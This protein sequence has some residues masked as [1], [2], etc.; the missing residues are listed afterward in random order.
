LVLAAIPEGMMK[1]IR[2]RFL[3]L[4]G[5]AAALPALSRFA[6]A[7]TYPTRPVRM[8]VPFAPA[9]TTDIAARLIGQ[10]LSEHLG[11]PFVIENR[12][13]ANGNIGT[14]AVVRAPPDGYTLLM[15]DAS[16]AINATLYDKL[17]FNFTRDT[18]P[19]ATVVRAPLI[20]VVHPSVPAKTVPEFIAYAKANPGKINYGSAGIGSTLHVT[21]EL[22]KIM[23]GVDLVHVPYRGG[24]PAIAD[25]IA[26]QVQ[27]VFIPAP[28]GIE[29]VRGGALRALAVTAASRFEALPDLPTVGEH[30]PGFEASTWYGV[31]APRNTASAIIDSLNKEINAGLLDSKL[32]ARFTFVTSCA[33]ARSPLCCSTIPTKGVLF[34]PSRTLTTCCESSGLATTRWT[35]RHEAP[36]PI[37]QQTEPAAAGVS[38]E[39]AEAVTEHQPVRSIHVGNR[40]SCN[41]YRGGNCHHPAD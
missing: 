15:V 3:H 33:W 17:N 39:A 41:A 28:A 8:I 22:F 25:L 40:G 4:A 37:A 9:G 31:V 13:G 23:T 30:V 16:P 32:K 29:Y 18:A 1:L 20:L 27:A 6:G 24:G 35:S 2:R 5:G 38:C 34:S 19:I 7:Q 10:W 21:A 14:E 12:P 36:A 11:Q 26:G